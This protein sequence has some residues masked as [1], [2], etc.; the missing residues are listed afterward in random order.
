MGLSHYLYA[1]SVCKERCHVVILRTSCQ[2]SRRL[3]RHVQF[4]PG[5]RALAP[6]GGAG[7]GVSGGVSE[8]LQRGDGVREGVGS[9]GRVVAGGGEVGGGVL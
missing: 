8:E 3:L 9:D 1:A 6:L 4:S 2:Q 7:N 5:S